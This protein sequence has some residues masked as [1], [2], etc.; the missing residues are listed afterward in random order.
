MDKASVLGDA[1]EYMKNLKERLKIL[2]EQTS[3]QANIESARFEIATD[4]GEISSSDGNISCFSEQLPE[5][6]ARFIGND[7][8]IRIH[9]EKKP[10]VVGKTFAEIEKLHLSVINSSAVIFA[11][12][13]LHIIVIAQMDKDF[14]MT[15]KDFVRNLHLTLNQFM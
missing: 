4:G 1:I 12:C 13:M 5:I 6:K 8:L 9:C 11:N 3:K 10:G 15:M 2:E 7:V 14:T